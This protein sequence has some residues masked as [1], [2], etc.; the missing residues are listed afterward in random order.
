MLPR[1][2]VV[3]KIFAFLMSFFGIS[4]NMKLNFFPWIS[5]FEM[6]SGIEFSGVSRGFWGV[7]WGGGEESSSK[8]RLKFWKFFTPNFWLNSK[9]TAFLDCL[10]YWLK[11]PTWPTYFLTHWV[12]SSKFTK[13]SEE[14]RWHI[15]ETCSQFKQFCWQPTQIPFSKSKNWLVFGHKNLLFKLHFFW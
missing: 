6:L 10:K 5:T 8:S 7:F 14:H 3:M 2:F 4:E 15:P 11:I 13:N 12:N 1:I 9:E